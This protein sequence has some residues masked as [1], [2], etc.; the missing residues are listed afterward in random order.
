VGVFDRFFGGLGS[1]RD[2]RSAK[3][4]ELRGDLEKAVELYGLAGAPEEAAR[5][6]ILRGDAETDARLRMRHYTQAVATAPEGHAVRGEARRKRAALLV[7]QFGAAAHSEAARRELREAGKELLALGDAAHAASAFRLAGDT[8]GEAKALTQA[9]DVESLEF[10][11]TEQQQKERAERQR[12]ELHA[13]FELLVSTGRRR[14]AVD[15]A[16]R[17][18]AAHAEDAT[19]RERVAGIRAR[20]ALG[21]IAQV[22]IRGT[23]TPIALGDEVVI[24]RTEG[25]IRIPS[26]AVSRQHLRVVRESGVVVVRDLGSRNGTQLRGMNLVGALPVG[27]GL[28]LTL[29]KEVRLRVAPSTVLDGAVAIEVAGATYAAP[30]GPARISG[31]PWEL[32]CGADGW[33]E[34]VSHGAAPLVA[35][36]ELGQ[37]TTLLVGD[38]LSSER[39]G[40]E[41]LRVVG[42]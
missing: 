33:I 5:V 38:V 23:A 27:D 19:L 34:L 32:V 7:D 37:R 30:L 21:P 28:D 42:E 26:Q 40:G 13:D 20:R 3:R 10:L 14:E 6:M 2:V 9:G 31:V 39:G 11:L 41:V 29:G 4:A 15:K 18:L 16:E 35:D 8:D 24:G 25:T 36:V 12:N 17:W 22:W 1:R